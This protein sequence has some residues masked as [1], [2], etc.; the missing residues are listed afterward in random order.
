MAK[1][2]NTPESKKRPKIAQMP[3][4][5]TADIVTSV[6]FDNIKHPGLKHRDIKRKKN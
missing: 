2:L 5:K 1:S 4:L 6:N 3:H